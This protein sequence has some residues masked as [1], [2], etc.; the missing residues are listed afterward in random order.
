MNRKSGYTILRPRF[1]N[2][3]AMHVLDEYVIPN[4]PPRRHRVLAAVLAVVAFG[5]YMAVNVWLFT[6]G[7]MEGRSDNRT[8]IPFNVQTGST[9]TVLGE[10]QEQPPAAP[11]S[12]GA[13]LDA[14]GANAPSGP[15]RFACDALGKCNL[16]KNPSGA[17]CPATYADPRCLSQCGD[18]TKQ[19]KE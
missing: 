14:S 17:G 18:P 4:R 16:Y 7:R 19:C 3:N 8:D 10:F 12:F 5:G 6:L 9:A 1:L 15:G 11:S 13:V 2:N